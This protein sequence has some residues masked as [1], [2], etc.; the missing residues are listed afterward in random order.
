MLA[1]APAATRMLVDV[2]VMELV[3]LIRAQ[4]APRVLEVGCGCGTESLWAA[5]QGGDVKAASLP[6]RPRKSGLPD[7]RTY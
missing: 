4:K 7:L 6:S 2:P 5:I 3:E 1:G